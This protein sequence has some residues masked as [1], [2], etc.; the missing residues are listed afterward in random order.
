MLPQLSETV[1]EFS[2][3]N[4]SPNTPIIGKNAFVHNAGL[5]VAAVLND[6]AY[7]EIISPEIVGRKRTF[8]LDKMASIHT[9]KQKL[10]TMGLAVN[11]KNVNNIMQY[12]K[13]KEKGTISDEELKGLLD[14]NYID[15]IMF[16]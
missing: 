1:A 16:Q 12:V 11:N 13:S 6:P 8:V 5:H 14:I 4:I 2:G 3:L 10:E 9:I 15:S 7:Y